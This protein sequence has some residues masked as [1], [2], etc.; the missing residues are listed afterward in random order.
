MVSAMATQ[1]NSDDSRRECSP[2]RGTGKVI[3]GLNGSPHQ[4]TCPWC[5]GSGQFQPGR[6]AQQ[7]PSETSLGAE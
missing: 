5:G 7:A 3:S 1:A 4:V 6:D 2:C